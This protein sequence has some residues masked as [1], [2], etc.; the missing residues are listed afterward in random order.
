[1]YPM[2]PVSLRLLYPMSPVSLRLLYPMSP[3]SLRLLYPMSPVSLDCTFWIALSVFPNICLLSFLVA[4][5]AWTVDEYRTH[6]SK[7]S[8]IKPC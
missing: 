6:K 8:R 3:V 2:S 4:C 5:F 7:I 1:L